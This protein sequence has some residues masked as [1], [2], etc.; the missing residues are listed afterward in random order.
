[1]IRV[2]WQ[3]EA[4]AVRRLVV[5]RADWAPDSP[6]AA[7]AARAGLLTADETATPTPGDFWLGCSPRS[8]WDCADP[9]RVG[10]AC[11]VEVPHALAVLRAASDRAPAAEPPADPFDSRRPADDFVVR[12]RLRHTH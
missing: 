4:L 6:V 12:D 7:L 1:M 5:R 3:N 11:F 2:N 9:A 10:W 8:G